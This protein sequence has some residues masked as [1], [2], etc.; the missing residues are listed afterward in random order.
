M[1]ENIACYKAPKGEKETN[2]QY[3]QRTTRCLKSWNERFEQIKD[4]TNK[5]TQNLKEKEVKKDS[6][7]S[8]DSTP[9]FFRQHITLDF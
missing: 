8:S 6:C 7:I 3:A 5:I 1:N 2:E 4:R 9:H